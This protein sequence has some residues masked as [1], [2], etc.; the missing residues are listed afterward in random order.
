MSYSRWGGRGSGHWYTFWCVQD[1]ETENR[2]TAVF[3]ICAVLNF[4]A[5]ELREDMTKCMNEASQKDDS[6]GDLKELQ[7]YAEEF[8]KEVDEDYPEI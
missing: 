7:T 8:L 1:E 3:A 2:D 6:D 4:T 5:K